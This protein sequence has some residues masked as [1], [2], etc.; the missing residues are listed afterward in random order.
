M[1][2]VH[3]DA[4]SPPHIGTLREGALHADLRA[5]YQRRGDRLEVPL[6]GYVIDLVRDGQLV[7]FQTGSFSPLRRKLPALLSRH[8]VRLVVPIV[9]QRFILRMADTGELMSER[10]SPK[11]GRI[12]DVFAALVSIPGL[13]TH[14]RFTLEALLVDIDEI[15]VHRPG[16]AFRRRGWVVQARALRKVHASRVFAAVDDV[17][18]L[19]PPALPDCF[20]T[21]ELASTTGLPRRLAQQML[22]CLTAMGATERVGKSGNAILYRRTDRRVS[23]A[24]DRP[25]RG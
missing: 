1:D 14:P 3:D 16:R 18:A 10:R 19:L 20:G 6:D 8:P 23:A 22:Y 9:A 21:A 12:E 17:A 13:L 2:A 24:A 15:R 4:P 7:E 25:A 5:W 11:R